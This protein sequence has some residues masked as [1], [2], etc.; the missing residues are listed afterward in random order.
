MPVV[1]VTGRADQAVL[2]LARAHPEVTL[3]PKPFSLEELRRH[4]GA[5]AP[6]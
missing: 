3:L 6:A 5:L 2:D 1:L 4:L